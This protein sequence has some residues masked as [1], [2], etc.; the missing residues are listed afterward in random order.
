[1]FVTDLT[2]HRAESALLLGKQWERF[3]SWWLPITKWSGVAF[4]SYS[5]LMK[6]LTFCRLMP[7]SET[8]YPTFARHSH[9]TFY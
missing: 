5:N 6:H 8:V 3:A 4:A 7:T 9:P 2:D 1:M